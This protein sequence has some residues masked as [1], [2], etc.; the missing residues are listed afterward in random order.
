MSNGRVL[1]WLYYSPVTRKLPYSTC[2][3]ELG[4]S[5]NLSANEKGEGFLS[6]QMNWNRCGVSARSLIKT[7]Q[8]SYLFY[9]KKGFYMLLKAVR[10]YSFLKFDDRVQLYFCFIS[11]CEWNPC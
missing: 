9:T 3:H 7:T 8:D 5:I 10:K 1:V 11:L 4:M 2:W 6:L